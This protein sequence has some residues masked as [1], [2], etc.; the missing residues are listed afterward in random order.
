MLELQ[1]QPLARG[2]LSSLCMYPGTYDSGFYAP[3]KAVQSS[4]DY[5]STL[6]L[7]DVM[8]PFLAGCTNS[9]LLQLRLGFALPAAQPFRHL[10]RHGISTR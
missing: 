3:H 10:Q 6:P 1:W 9:S 5:F 8:L 7:A 2:S 4:I